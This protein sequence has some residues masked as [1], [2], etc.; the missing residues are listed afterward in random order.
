MMHYYHH[1]FVLHSGNKI[2]NAHLFGKYEIDIERTTG[3][4]GHGQGNPGHRSA[5]CLWL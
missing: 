4:Q 3:E 5:S 1:Y 2:Y